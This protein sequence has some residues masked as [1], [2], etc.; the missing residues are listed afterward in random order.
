MDDAAGDD[1]PLNTDES[2]SSTA[3]AEGDEAVKAA[4]ENRDSDDEV[5]SELQGT[6]IAPAPDLMASR[7][8]PTVL[9]ESESGDE[10]NQPDSPSSGGAADRS[11]NA[12]NADTI[13][14]G[15]PLPGFP[16]LLPAPQ[17]VQKPRP[18]TSKPLGQLLPLKPGLVARAVKLE[19]G[20]LFS[21]TPAVS[22]PS[23]DPVGMVQDVAS[24][25][26]AMASLQPPSAIS[27]D[28]AAA[29]AA[30][31][32]VDIAQGAEF[33]AAIDAAPPQAAVDADSTSPP[34]GQLADADLAE[35]LPPDEPAGVG[36]TAAVQTAVDT[37]PANREAP[38][39]AMPSAAAREE[40]AP[41]EPPTTD[42]AAHNAVDLEATREVAGDA[43]SEALLGSVPVAD[44]GAAEDTGR[45]EVAQVEE[46]FTDVE[47]LDDGGATAEGSVADVAAEAGLEVQ[48]EDGSAVESSGAAAADLTGAVVP[49]DAGPL[50]AEVAAAP[51]DE[52]QVDDGA[53]AAA[54]A[55]SAPDVASV[56]GAPPAA[57][58]S[59]TPAADATGAGVASQA[60]GRAAAAHF[61]RARS[62]VADSVDGADVPVG[63]WGSDAV[64]AAGGD[65]A[66]VAYGDMRGREAGGDEDVAIVRDAG[67]AAGTDELREQDVPPLPAGI[68]EDR[69]TN[70][71]TALAARAVAEAY[72]NQS[73]PRR[74]EPVV[75]EVPPRLANAAE[76]AAASAAAVYASAKPRT[77]SPFETSGSMDEADGGPRRE[78]PPETIIHPFHLTLF[79]ILLVGGVG[80]AITVINFTTDMGWVWSSV[81]V[82]RKL[83]KSLAFRQTIALLVAIAFVR[84]GLEP[85]VRSVRSVFALPGQWERSN[86]YF[87]LKQ[88]CPPPADR[89]HTRH[90]PALHEQHRDFGALN[91][92]RSSSHPLQTAK[93]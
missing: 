29:E 30:V 76:A 5:S 1:P 75:P 55:D 39:P 72:A 83:A 31:K 46:Y 88:V 8:M 86:E 61:T 79:A 89:M 64:D 49:R 59:G 44:A 93:V 69:P 60:D 41:M 11:D 19:D 9:S 20:T 48:G 15:V 40:D 74:G 16:R 77:D 85:L 42:A 65:A 87:I 73:L 63:G 56:A 13:A 43:S 80:F 23:G 10:P 34:D 67:S 14:G 7:Q 26:A 17:P 52:P 22:A 92:Q 58:A 84:Y 47:D 33:P 91:P 21:F 4:A 27:A 12:D 51:A 82:L 24:E 70:V 66:I 6:K 35:Q 25:A 37:V 36:S 71:P 18:P 3:P 53:A 54:A 32:D 90:F 81:R 2:V 62:D 28:P 38:D 45:G 57:D 68:R 50:G 78:P